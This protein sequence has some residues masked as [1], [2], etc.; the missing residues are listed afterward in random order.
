M[1]FPTPLNIQVEIYKLTQLGKPVYISVPSA[2]TIN[3]SNVTFYDIRRNI[4]VPIELLDYRQDPYKNTT[5][6]LPENEAFIL[7]ITDDL[8]SCEAF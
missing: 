5:N 2:R 1:K 7:P 3:I 8:K 6:A 4:N